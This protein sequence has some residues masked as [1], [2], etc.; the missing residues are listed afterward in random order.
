MLERLLSL[1]LITPKSLP[2]L[3]WGSPGIGKSFRIR[4]LGDAMALLTETLI[5]SIREPGDF[6]GM[7]MPSEE[8]IR[9][10]PPA[11]AKRLAKVGK[12]LVFIDEISCTPPATQAALLRVVHEGVVGELT[13]PEGVKFIAAANPPEEAAGGWDLA[14]PLANRFIHLQLPAPSIKAWSDWLLGSAD[15]S[16]AI[17]KV[18]EKTWP[19]RFDRAFDRAKTMMA[20]FLRK[21]PTELMEDTKKT[22]GRN[23]PAYATPR[24]MECA[25][26]LYATT[27]AT[28]ATDA[29]MPLLAGAVGE[30]VATKF[31]TWV[32]EAD[33][34]DPED[35]LKDPDSWT[36]NPS[37]QDATFAVLNAVAYAATE[38]RPSAKEY[39]GRWKA[40]W[41]VMERAMKDGK[42]LV[43]IAAR[44]LAHADHRPK[45]AL[46]DKR[47]VGIITQL[48]EVIKESGLIG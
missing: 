36:P 47:I 22:Q 35:L 42:D 3:L 34:P 6:G 28:G 1:V 7:P 44:R 14:A 17:V 21:F 33:L 46:T 41:L 13:L 19:E 37:R 45:G 20:G 15:G 23:P 31:L 32:R 29:Q 12:G 27:L 48:R 40:A 43:V 30:G 11:W 24:T 10:D 9:L 4:R 8:G 16:E 18:D 26:R 39:E 25:T 2:I 5:A 38:N